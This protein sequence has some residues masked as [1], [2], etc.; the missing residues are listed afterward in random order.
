MRFSLTIS[1]VPRVELNTA[2]T[3]SRAPVNVV[4]R[5]DKVFHQ[6][7][8]A[9][10]NMIVRSLPATEEQISIIRNQQNKD[11]VCCKLKAYCQHEKIQWIGPLKRYYPF[12]TKLAVADRLLLKGEKSCD[13]QVITSR[14]IGKIAHRPSRNQVSSESKRLCVVA[15]NK[16]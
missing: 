12:R 9:Y 2:D 1:L 7:V 10:V 13:T 4:E 8:D 5:S 6:E 3:L 14:N 11:P 16:T 15:G